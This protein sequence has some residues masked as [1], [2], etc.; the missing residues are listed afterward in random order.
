MAYSK[1]FQLVDD[2]SVHFDEAVNSA[3]AF[4]QSRYVGFYAVAAAAVLELALKEVIVEFARH[5]HSLFGDYL[6]SR[7]ER[8]NGRIGLQAISDEHLKPFGSKFQDRFNELLKDADQKS[9]RENGFSTKHSYAALFVCRHQF[10]H[11]G[12]VPET[13]SYADIKRGFEA[14]KIVMECLAKTLEGT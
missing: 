9:I 4:L 2:V 8:I 13:T 11:E 1:H 6:A 10:S 3:N 7:Y 14:G 5:H 12:S